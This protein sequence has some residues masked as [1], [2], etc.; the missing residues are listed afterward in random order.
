MFNE[1][2]FHKKGNLLDIGCEAGFFLYYAKP[3]CW[4]MKSIDLLDE[5]IQFV[6]EK[7]MIKNAQCL[8]LEKAL[9]PDQFFDLVTL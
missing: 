5:Y 6:K 9:F 1:R 7:L 2:F 4:S 3:K 8:S